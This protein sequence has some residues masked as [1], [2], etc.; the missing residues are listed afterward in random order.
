MFQ[1]V[2]LYFTAPRRDEDAYSALLDRFRANLVNRGSTPAAHFSDTLQIT[3]SQG[4]PRARPPGMYLL[5]EMDLDRSLAFYRDRF[6]DA[7]DFT[8]VIVGAIDLA[9]IR[10]LVETYL[11]GL[12]STGRDESWR[13]HDIRPP[14]G[15]VEKVVR[16]GIEPRSQT[17]IMIAGPFTDRRED[18]YALGSLADALELRLMDVLREELGGTYGVGTSASVSLRPEPRYTFAIGFGAAPERLEELTDAVF[19]QIRILA[20]EGPPSEDVE[21]IREQQRRARET[22]LRENSFWAG[23]ILAYHRDGR[24]L[25]DIVTFD[26]LL[27]TLSVDLIRTAA[28]N[29]L[30]TGEYIR[31]SLYPAADP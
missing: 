22:S 18:A 9:A 30:D 20:E 10:P 29:W 25:E 24:S 28:R 2:Y 16:Y 19:E 21:K 11:G 23:Q 8:F 1:L 15:V 3:L 17:Q 12:P 14:S 4:H 13:D 31:V 27:A 7:S 6:E 26:R 5:D